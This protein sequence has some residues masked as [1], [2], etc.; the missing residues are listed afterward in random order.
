M[1]EAHKPGKFGKAAGGHKYIPGDLTLGLREGQRLARGHTV[2]K[3]HLE[4]TQ[5]QVFMAPNPCFYLC[6]YLFYYF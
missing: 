2:N 6:I 4:R 1:L 5:T 3:K